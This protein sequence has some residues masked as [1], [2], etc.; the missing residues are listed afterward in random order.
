M[1]IRDEDFIRGKVP[2]TKYYIRTLLIG[3]LEIKAGDRFLDIG[4]GTGSISVEA[5]LR[6]AKV[7]SIDKNP[8]SV[9]LTVENADK[10]KV[11]LSIFEGNAPEDLPDITIGKC[12]VGGSGGNLEKIFDYLNKNLEASGLLVGSFITLKNLEE[13]RRLLKEYGYLEIETVLAQISTEDHIGLM[14]GENPIFIVRGR[15]ND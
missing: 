6:G 10:F 7:Y 14:R 1:W 4:S 15:K 13:F 3:V 8:E 9:R 5:A 12:F 11:N 2:M